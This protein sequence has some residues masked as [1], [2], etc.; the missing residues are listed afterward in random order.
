MINDGWM[1]RSVHGVQC[2]YPAE[3]LAPRKLENLRYLSQLSD[4]AIIIQLLLFIWPLSD[5]GG[6][7][8]C[9]VTSLLCDVARTK[10][11]VGEKCSLSCL[12]KF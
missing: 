12:A 11:Q 1:Q 4:S 5:R 7:C 10:F 9:E 8:H 6:G 3:H 2:C